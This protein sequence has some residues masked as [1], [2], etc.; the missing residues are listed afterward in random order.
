MGTVRQ[1]TGGPSEVLRIAASDAQRW[2]VE[3]DGY[4]RRLR[5]PGQNPAYRLS[6]GTLVLRTASFGPAD[7]K[8]WSCE[9]QVLVLRTA[10]FGPA[11]G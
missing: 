6:L 2:C 7:G 8:F 11:N 5:S 3:I 9:R 1:D 4:P 10:S